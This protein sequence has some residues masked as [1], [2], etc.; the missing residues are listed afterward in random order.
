MHFFFGGLLLL[1]G[2]TAIVVR[3]RSIFDRRERVMIDCLSILGWSRRKTYPLD[4]LGGVKLT[5]IRWKSSVEYVA[6]VV[7]PD[8]K[9]VTKITQTFDP[10]EV[11]VR[12]EEVAHFTGLKMIDE[13][14]GTPVIREGTEV[15]ESLRDRAARTGVETDLPP[16]PPG[17]RITYTIRKDTI[18]FEIPPHGPGTKQKLG[19][20]AAAFCA[21]LYLILLIL[22]VTCAKEADPGAVPAFAALLGVI[23]IGVPAF[24]AALSYRSV[25]KCWRIEASPRELRV[26]VHGFLRKGETVLPADSIEELSVVDVNQTTM[27]DGAPAEAQGKRLLLARSDTA[28]V[29]FADG[30]SDDELD[31]LKAVIT[32][33]LSI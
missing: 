14:T 22:I 7:D 2:L 5:M 27:T 11:R 20:A 26:F 23:L 13:T 10:E 32:K 30:L 31:W 4:E 3:E 6:Q 8:G 29:S 12:A 21:P 19:Y 25:T 28:R 17:A 15:D 24:L 33:T 16:Q 1:L 18:I 9:M